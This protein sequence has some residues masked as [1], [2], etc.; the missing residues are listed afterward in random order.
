LHQKQVLHDGLF[1]HCLVWLK[2]RIKYI[3]SCN[4][5]VKNTK[6]EKVENKDI[7]VINSHLLMR[8]A[9]RKVA[10]AKP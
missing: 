5:V 4:E 7:Y 8:L 2:I 3:K 10:R 9:G 1:Y 6:T